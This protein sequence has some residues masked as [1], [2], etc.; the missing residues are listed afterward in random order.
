MASLADP[1]A[2]TDKLAFA[3]EDVARLVLTSREM[4]RLEEE[5]LVPAR[6]VLY[7]FSARGHDMA[8]VMLG[9]H[10]REGDAACGY[11]RSRPMLLALGVELADALGSNMGRE[12]GYSDG[13]DIGVVF[14]YPNPGGAHALPMCGGVGAQ[15][16]PAAGWAQ[17]ITYKAKVLGEKDDGAIAVVLGGDASCATGG[18]WSA[19]TI[20]TTQNLPLLFFIEDN[21]YGISVTSDYQTPGRN[22]A[23]NLSSF[24]NLT[25][26]DGDGTDPESAARQIGEAVAHVRNRKG[27]VLCRLTVPRLEGH[28]AQDTQAYK[29]DEEKTAEW[30]RDPLPKLKKLA[31]N[32]DWDMIE[33]SVAREVD[34]A[35]QE[36][37]ARA[38]SDPEKVTSGVFFEGE[39]A[40]V[41]GQAGLSLEGTH[42]DPRPEGQRINMVTAIRRVL[43]QELE[44]N[45]KMSV[46]GEDVGPKGGV[47][48]V[49][50]GLQDK[51]G[52]ERVFD[53]SLNEEGIVGRAIGMAMAGL[54]PVPEIQFRKYAEP[55]TE[56]INDCGT[57]R[58][59]THNRF[60]A[61]MV[62]RIPGGFFKCGDP[63][64]SQTNEVQF[65]HNP[66]WRV[67]VPSNAEDAVGL[68]RMALRGN[69]PTIFFEH[70]AML[71][72][73]WARRPYPGDGYVLPFGKAKKTMQGD[74]ITIVTW[75]AM[76]PRCEAA[77]KDM[78]ADVIDLRT[79]QP[80]D[81]DMVLESVAKTHRCLI[82]HEDL[83]TGG[84][85]A[86]IAAVVADEAFLDLDAPVERVT[87]PDIP[88]PHHPKLLE[89]AVP[90]VEDI[91]A[92]ITEMLEF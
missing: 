61:P 48:A 10:L 60:A 36:A 42:E 28:S 13:R 91:R 56:Q 83:R 22:I 54:L 39:Q 55:A 82:V 74:R 69:D 18:F 44:A 81:K 26:F 90:S 24:K 2:R 35:R 37:E 53:T 1:A 17:A 67:A 84:F 52:K 19:L 20:A 76:V 66:G 11:Y 78:G 75:G 5:E 8:Q 27:P 38:V 7:Q 79:L 57:I 16:T 88:S 32:L 30:A 87:M 80:W 29:S 9:L 49:T 25:I 23:A 50:L 77:A 59:R 72:D 73:S 33:A 85:G 58:W 6:K 43:D 21:G 92:K 89:A 65:V 45:P 51:Y 86:E 3:W 34:A 71:D 4:D 47:H 68:L 64:H 46:F 70:R 63:W 40:K 41:G 14:N 12:G 31:D 15:Y 62:L